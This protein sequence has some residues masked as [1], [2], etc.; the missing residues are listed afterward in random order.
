MDTSR[1]G[2]QIAIETDNDYRI[3]VGDGA[4]NWIWQ[5]TG[6]PSKGNKWTHFA[7]TRDGNTFRAYEDGVLLGTQTSSTA[8]GNPRG[9]AIGGQSVDDSTNY[10]FNGYISNLRIVNGSSVYN[11]LTISPLP[12]EPL[13]N[14][15]NTK[16]LCCQS[17][18]SSA[19]AA[20]SPN[21]S[22]SINDGTELEFYCN[23]TH[24]PSR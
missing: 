10:G 21:I 2:I 24:S 15:T 6:F 9:P 22:G 19:I 16:L 17:N 13:T 1:S 12:T 11:G 18:K 4:G 3:E 20:A 5:S 7:L 8:V 23:W 14:I